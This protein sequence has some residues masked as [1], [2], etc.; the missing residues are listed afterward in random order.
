MTR[1]FDEMLPL[2]ELAE[3]DES[4]VRELQALSRRFVH[5]TRRDLYV[6]G[7]AGRD[8]AVTTANSFGFIWT[9]LYFQN[10]KFQAR[11]SRRVK[12]AATS[13]AP[14]AAH[15]IVVTTGHMTN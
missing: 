2:R 13:Y 6:L 8:V 15:S 9:H 3:S 4:F 12:R 7:Q 5:L 11:N 10:V 14:T 1:K